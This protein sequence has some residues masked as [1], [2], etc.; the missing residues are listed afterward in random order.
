MASTFSRDDAIAEFLTLLEKQEAGLLA[1]GVADGSFAEDELDDHARRFLDSHAV[2]DD[3]PEPDAMVAALEER[4]LLF[5][6]R[7]GGRWRYRTRQAEAVRLLLRLRQLF[8]KHAGG[9]WRTAPRLVA[10]ARFLT[11]PRSFPR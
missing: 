11:R 5:P 3:F 9:G 6:F 4:R 10:D 8:P 7:A 1:W 2:W